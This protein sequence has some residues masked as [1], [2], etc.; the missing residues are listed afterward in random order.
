MDGREALAIAFFLLASAL[1]LFLDARTMPI[2]LWDESRNVV[3]A[4]EMRRTG[5]GLVTTYGFEPDLWN[6]KPPLLIWL[7][8]ASAAL[9][10][11][12]E[13]ALRLPSALASLGTLLILIL[14]VRRV[15]GSLGCGLAAAGILLLSPG[16]FGEHG[17][18]TADYDSLLLFFTTLYLQLLFFAVH[19]RRPSLALLAAAGAAIACACL[20]KSVA[21]LVPGAGLAL[22]L[23]FTGRWRRIVRNVS[24][25]AVMTAVAAIPVLAYYLAR[26]AAVPGY[27]AAAFRNDVLGRVRESLVG[28]ES[29]PSFYA[30]E[31]A[32][33]WFFAGPVLIGAPL[34]LRLLRGKARTLFVFSL[35]AGAA[36]LLVYSFATTKL[37]HYGLPAFP[38]LAIVVALALRALWR[39]FI[40]VPAEG[41]PKLNAMSLLLILAAG[42]LLV[43]LGWRAAD[44]RYRIFPQRQ[45]YAQALYG[46]L[47]AALAR[48]GVSSATIVDPGFTL[49]GKPH[50]TPLLRA[51]RLIWA[52]RGLQTGERPDVPLGPAGLLASCDPQTAAQLLR[53]GRDI[54][55]VAGCAAIRS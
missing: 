41:R 34:A 43:H 48:Q 19:R 32:A 55:G 13:W 40:A 47:F 30:G 4:L 28:R 20:T 21:G 22:Y 54:G 53:L 9:F 27:L 24:G 11:P 49:E 12:S 50:Y 17:A 26:D 38:W 42:A 39:R 15:A 18:R 8:T 31:L 46:E 23:L 14:F 35:A 45:F 1:F 29:G 10:G 6:T 25:Y 44:W 5:I 33:G 2:V 51:Y 37:I 3:N 52:E 16:F 36:P 7:M